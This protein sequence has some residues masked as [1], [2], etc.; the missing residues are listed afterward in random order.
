MLNK[1]LTRFKHSLSRV[2][3]NRASERRVLLAGWYVDEYD[4]TNT[5]KTEEKQRKDYI[6]KL[7]VKLLQVIKIFIQEVALTH[8]WFS[9][10]T[11]HYLKTIL[12][13]KN[14]KYVK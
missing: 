14:T 13:N 6:S 8:G 4:Y 12:N 10:E 2:H 7:I 9:D 5:F 3:Q 11:C 1:D